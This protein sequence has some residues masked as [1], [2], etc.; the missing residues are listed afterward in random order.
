[1]TVRSPF[2]TLRLPLATFTPSVVRS[3]SLWLTSVYGPLEPERFS[4]S[5]HRS[6]ASD[7]VPFSFDENRISS[8]ADGARSSIPSFGTDPST[9]D[10]TRAVMYHGCKEPTPT[11][12]RVTAP[13]VV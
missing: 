6:G 5:T 12:P 1:M 13:V 2:V 4:Y 9:H 8:L 11:T 10:L 7:E 3:V